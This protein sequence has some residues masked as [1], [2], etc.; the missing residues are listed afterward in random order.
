MVPES[1]YTAD[2]DAI[3]WAV[4]PRTKIVFLANPNNP[5]GTYLAFDEIKRV[6]RHSPSRVLLVLAAPHAEYADCSDYKFS[7]IHASPPCGWAGFMAPPERSMP[8]TVFAALQCQPAR[9]HGGSSGCDRCRTYRDRGNTQCALAREIGKRGLT[10][11]PTV[12]NVLLM[13]FP[14]PAGHTRRRTTMRSYAPANRPH[15]PQAVNARHHYVR[16]HN[17]HGADVFKGALGKS[18]SGWL[19]NRAVKLEIFPNIS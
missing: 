8:S 4:T 6:R 12:A 15:K 19:I 14:T 16:K 7:K 9:D 1:N 18:S 17:R 3:L 2:V 13:H 5:T 10:V 11:T